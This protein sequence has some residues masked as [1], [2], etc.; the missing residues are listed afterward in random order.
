MG[1][2]AVLALQKNG[3]YLL[4]VDIEA[5]TETEVQQTSYE[6]NMLAEK[7]SE[8]TAAFS[9]V[10][11]DACRDNS[12]KAKGRS[13][14]NTR[15]LSAIEPAKG[16]MVVY[17]ASKGQQALDRLSEKDAKPEQYFYAHIH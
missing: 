11:V 16:Q 5:T 13:V 1:R 8:A 2:N 6:L 15:G 3:A 4:P 17:S 12:L 7:L 9:L 10:M 14:G